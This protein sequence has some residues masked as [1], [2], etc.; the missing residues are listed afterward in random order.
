MDAK[1]DCT[2]PAYICGPLTE[3]LVDDQ[4]L[5]KE[6]YSLLAD[7]CGEVLGVRGWVPHEHYDPVA[8]AHFTPKEVYVAERNIVRNCS[9][10]VV[11]AYGPSWGGGM[12]VAWAAE[13]GIPGI[14]ICEEWKLEK[15]LISRLLRGSPIFAQDSILPS[16]SLRNAGVFL[17][18]WLRRHAT[19]INQ[20]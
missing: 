20:A 5:M 6:F 18:D 14:L 16:S 17:R 9:L 15:R 12:E 1:I 19:E 7:I 8:H 11:C 13:H 10:L 4:Q 3:L 2:K